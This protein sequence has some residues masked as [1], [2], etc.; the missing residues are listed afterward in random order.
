MLP[1][2]TSIAVLGFIE[3][4]SVAKRFCG[5]PFLP[6]PRNRHTHTHTTHRTRVWTTT[7]TNSAHV[8]VVDRL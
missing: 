6:R 3:G 2:A 7:R 4:I 5:A 1:P 8:V